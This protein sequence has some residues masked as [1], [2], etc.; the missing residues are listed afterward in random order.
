MVILSAVT[1]YT[2]AYRFTATGA[3]DS[4]FLSDS[5][6]NASWLAEDAQNIILVGGTFSSIGGEAGQDCQN[7]DGRQRGSEFRSGQRHHG[8]GGE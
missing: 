7:L 2:S 4:N 3:R 1:F 8:H 5:K 6:P